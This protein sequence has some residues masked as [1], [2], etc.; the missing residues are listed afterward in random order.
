MFPGLCVCDCVRVCIPVCWTQPRAVLKRMNRSRCRLGCGL[1]EPCIRRGSRSPGK[2]HCGAPTC[3]KLHLMSETRYRLGGGETIC[4]PP[5]A[6]RRWHIVSRRSSWI[7]KSLRI[8]VRPR[9][10][11]QSAHLWWPAV[12]KLQAASVPIDYA[13]SCAMGQTDGWIAHRAGA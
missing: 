13:G 12:A 6:V 9:T 5:T 3:C 4:P 10:G 2:E 11:W 8:Y 1:W 7:Q